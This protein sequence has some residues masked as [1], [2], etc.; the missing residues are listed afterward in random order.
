M[1]FR[2]FCDSGIRQGYPFSPLAFVLW[3]ELLAIT[4]RDCKGTKGIT[5]LLDVVNG[6]DLEQVLKIVLYADDITL[7]W[8]KDYEMSHALSIMIFCVCVCVFLAWR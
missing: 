4:I 5:T 7:F 3:V 1:A 2:L 6:T 8:G